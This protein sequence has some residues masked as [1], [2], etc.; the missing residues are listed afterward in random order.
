MATIAV[1]SC[2]EV[3]LRD[4][5]ENWMFLRWGCT[6]Q[7]QQCFFLQN[8]LFSR[9]GEARFQRNRA[10][11][12]ISYAT[13]CFKS[14][15]R[16]QSANK[17]TETVWIH[18]LTGNVCQKSPALDKSPTRS[19]RGS[20][21]GKAWAAPREGG[22]SR[23]EALWACTSLQLGFFHVLLRSCGYDYNNLHIVVPPHRN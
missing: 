18:S 14:W 10:V 23:W 17:E 15:S 2:L 22:H 19:C 21:A 12:F 5:R 6:C 20:L 13:Y 16:T 8:L 7:L 4:L 9:F 11:T 1:F 3:F